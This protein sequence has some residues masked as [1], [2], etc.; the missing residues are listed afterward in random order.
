[1]YGFSNCK[2]LDENLIVCPD[3]YYAKTKLSAEK[4]VLGARR[5]DGQLL[6]KMLRFGAVY[7][8]C[9]KCNSQRLVKAFARGR[10]LMLG[11]RS[12]RVL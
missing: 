4:I 8:T 5:K 3:T 10:F 12:N 7:G 1:M 6:G 2:I 9:I 11:D